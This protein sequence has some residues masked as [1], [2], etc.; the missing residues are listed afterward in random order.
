MDVTPNDDVSAAG[1]LVERTTGFGAQEVVNLIPADLYEACVRILHDRDRPH[2]DGPWSE[3]AAQCGTVMHPLVQFEALCGEHPRSKATHTYDFIQN[4]TPSIGRLDEVMFIILTDL[5]GGHTPH[6]ETVWAGIWHGLGCFP[7]GWDAA[8]TFALPGREYFLFRVSLA[9]AA[10][11]NVSN[12]DPSTP[13]DYPV[14]PNLWWSDDRAWI[15]ASE[16]DLDSTL[17]AGSAALA[18]DILNHP[19]LEAFPVGPRDDLTLDGDT[20][21]LRP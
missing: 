10:T 2:A 4:N 7:A 8:A 17:V 15:V 11:I 6:D 5:L 13:V 20:V 14:Y 1:W 9:E 21:N 18:D 12:W 19:R 3:V 16:I